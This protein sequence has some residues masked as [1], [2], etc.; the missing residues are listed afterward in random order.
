LLEVAAGVR[1]GS[2]DNLPL[3]GPVGPA[4]LLVAS[5]HHRNGIL[6]APVTAEAIVGLLADGAATDVVR[7][8]DPA[9]LLR[10]ANG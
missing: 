7:V 3:I 5:G 8:A 9:R 2:P 1:P 6:L 10:R 4:G